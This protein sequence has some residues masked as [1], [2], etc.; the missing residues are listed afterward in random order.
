MFPRRREDAMSTNPRKTKTST[1]APGSKK[2]ANAPTA[3]KGVK[4]A[5]AAKN[6]VT[7]RMF[8]QGLGDCFLITAPQ[9]GARPYSILIDCGV[10]MG[11]PQADVIMPR[12]VQEIATLTGGVVDLLVVTHQHWDHVSGFLQATSALKTIEFKHL[13][14]AWTEDP[15][16]DLAN[17]L[18]K[19]FAK[20]KLALARALSLS[21]GL[22]STDPKSVERMSALAGVMAFL[23]PAVGN[24]KGNIA[25]A[26]KVPATLVKDPKEIEYLRPGDCENLP[27]ASGGLAAGIRAFTL[28]P[29]HDRKKLVRINPSTRAPE[30]YEKKS[31]DA[32]GLAVTWAWIAGVHAGPAA[33]AGADAGAVYPLSTPFEDK[34]GIPFGKA[35]KDEYFHLR[36][37]AASDDN[38]GRRIDGDWLWAGAQRLALQ[39]DTYTNNTSLVLAFELPDSKGVLLFPG[40]AQVGN[41]LSW[42]DQDYKT[43]DGRAVTAEKL[44]ANT[45]LYKV[46]HH[47]SHNATLKAR[48][49]ELMTF[50][51]LVAMLPVEA[52]GV[53]RLGYGQ[54]PLKSLVTALDARTSGRIL[55]VDHAWKANAPPGT[56]TRGGAAA[57]QSPATIS[58]GKPGA[59][60]SRTLY[61][62]CVVRD[63]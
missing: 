60:S 34:W 54:M 5:A 16:D 51:G 55:R 8:C 47:G 1:P 35:E 19:E 53:T 17:D 44:L 12:V 11:T 29:P 62:E 3:A 41:W 32:P 13:W 59:T 43:D 20:A 6:A 10:A 24:G 4:T 9:S 61:M 15:R 18:R 33:A 2:T 39:M 48:G 56:W 14:M 45:R 21:S 31:G 49:L 52:D 22:K 42:H 36:Y 26:M 28:G 37:F 57:A 25:D 38:V 63:E 58:V 50:P 40:D 23:G 46:G 7:V 27:G 30:T